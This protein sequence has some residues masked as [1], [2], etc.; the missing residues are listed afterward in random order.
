MPLSDIRS[1]ERPYS[2]LR[3]FFHLTDA[4]FPGGSRVLTLMPLDVVTKMDLIRFRWCV[5]LKIG[6]LVQDDGNSF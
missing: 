3:I 5:S 1:V 2:R 6:V 4:A